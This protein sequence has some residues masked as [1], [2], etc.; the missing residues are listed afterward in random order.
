[1]SYGI[2]YLLLCEKSGFCY[3]GQTVSTL[4]A[5]WK[6]H[7]SYALKL[8]SQWEISKA[9][10]EHGVDSF[11][12]SI[13]CECESK[14]ELNIKERQFIKEHNSVWPNGYNMT[15][16]GEGPCELTRRKI[17]LSHKGKKLS[18]EHRCNIGKSLQGRR[19][20]M[21]GKKHSAETKLKM[22]N[23]AMGKPK[24]FRTELHRQNLGKSLKGKWA[25]NKGLASEFQ[26]RFGKHCSEETK[27]KMR[28]KTHTN[29]TKQC[30]R[31]IHQ[32]L[33]D[34]RHADIVADAK[35][36]LT[37]DELV[38]K[39]QKPRRFIKRALIRALN[40]KLLTELP[41]NTYGNQSKA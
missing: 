17:S 24:G 41:T 36:G 33:V 35:L 8:K 12:L 40:R 5:R 2:V 20:A 19:G 14:E 21:L 10:R 27:Q 32:K 18:E 11:K 30:L 22:S 23:A 4:Q 7:C 13:L 34:N 31:E 9:I 1:M 15:N 38:N 25:W 37:F 26:P 29:E 39:F 3:I 6:G 16:G 28:T